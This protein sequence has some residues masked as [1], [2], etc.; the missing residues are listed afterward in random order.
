MLG[1]RPVLTV[2][3]PLA[4]LTVCRGLSVALVV[5]MG[6]WGALRFLGLML[7]WGLLM[8]AGFLTVQAVNARLHRWQAAALWSALLPASIVALPF[9]LRRI[10]LAGALE[11]IAI[12]VT[13]PVVIYGFADVVGRSRR[14]PSTERHARQD[15]PRA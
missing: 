2:I 7:I 13:V 5:E 12:Y 8:L 10:V 4:M 14:L 1:R 9:L 15:P 6:W 11:L 3:V